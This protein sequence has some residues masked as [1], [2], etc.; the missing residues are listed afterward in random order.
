MTIMRPMTLRNRLAREWT[1]P[2][3]LVSAVVAAG[4]AGAAAPDVKELPSAY[5]HAVTVEK[6][7]QAFGA[8]GMTVF[9]RIDHQAAAKGVGLT[10]LPTTV[11]IY[12]N[13]KG[14][15]PLMLDAPLLALDL[16]L[17]VLVHDDPAGRT[18]VAFHGAAGQ[19]TA[20]GLPAE[21]AAPLQKAEALIAATIAAQN[22][23]APAP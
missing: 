13:P 5:N 7:A 12:G 2:L 20:A 14:G 3:L 9:A 10:M 18:L 15:T 21:R 8:A 1:R 4:G 22:A 19:V 17:R 11:I 16:P 6:L 23:K